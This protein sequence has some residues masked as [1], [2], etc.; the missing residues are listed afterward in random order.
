MNR[1]GLRGD[2]GS[3][4]P[5]RMRK[6]PLDARGYPVPWFVAHRDGEPD[7]R[8]ADPIKRDR[9]IRARRCWICGGGLGKF[10]TFVVGPVTAITLS[11]SEP[12]SHPDCAKFA[13]RACPF[14]VLPNAKYRD[15]NLPADVRS[16]GGIHMRYNPGLS[17]LW[18]T[19]GYGVGVGL[20][21]VTMHPTEPKRVQFWREGRLATRDEVESCMQLAAQN[22]RT[23]SAQ[24]GQP[25]RE[26]DIAER[27]D[28]MA[29]W[30]PDVEVA[31]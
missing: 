17:L 21:G 26:A 13:V 27:L 3:I 10:L 4:I 30:Y 29:F 18:T 14:L 20:D 19:D 23:V 12:P 1:N 11:T 15:A 8:I 9:A 16:L 5:P 25:V 31:A 6:L 28:A 2:L 24:L 7:F 22:V